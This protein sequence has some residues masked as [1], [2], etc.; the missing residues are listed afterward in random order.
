MI[1]AAYR[2]I[3]VGDSERLIYCGL[4]GYV[5]LGI[6]INNRSKTKFAVVFESRSGKRY[7]M[8]QQDTIIRRLKIKTQ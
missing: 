3:A 6:S 2:V 8:A 5:A 4:D 1:A 7:S